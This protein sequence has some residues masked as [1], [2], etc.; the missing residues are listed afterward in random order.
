MRN[1]QLVAASEKRWRTPALVLCFALTW[2]M[3]LVPAIYNRFPLLFPDT[4]AY[5]KV[6]YGGYWTIDRSGFYGLMYAPMRLSDTSLG[7]WLAAAAQCAVVALIL[8]LFARRVAPKATPTALVLLIG[9]SALFTSLPWHAAQLM[10]DAYTAVL[11]LTVWLAASRN[12]DEPG[13]LLLWLLAALLALTHYTH[14]VLLAI[15][16]AAALAC[17]AATRIPASELGKRA[18]ALLI[19]VSAVAGTQVAVNGSLFGRW[20]VS[21]LGPWFMFAR[22]NE[23]G[24]VP[25]WFDGH[26]GKDGPEELCAIR[27]ALP[28]DSQVLLWSSSSPLYPVIHEQRGSPVTW[29]WVDMLEKAAMGSMREQPAAFARS[30]GR[31]ALE[32][33][34]HFRTLDDLCPQE[35]QFRQFIAEHPKLAGPIRSSRQLR[36]ELPKNMIRTVQT[37]IAAAGLLLLPALFFMARR[38]KDPLVA[39][40]IATT[41]I[42]LFA[43]AALAGGLSD[44]HDRYQ[45]RVVWLAPFVVLLVAARWYAWSRARIRKT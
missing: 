7:L 27:G 39:G 5:L 29:H 42:C 9:A 10:P 18:V 19:A 45:S 20:T 23:D 15:G 13:T 36:K 3:L 25:R 43:N 30:M 41:S 12:L 8:L 28:K 24:L 1:E 17:G 37:P 11:I 38:R 26:C 31:G 21:P 33:F 22:L 4:S 2:A 14:F 34:V 44:V 35:C 6:A 40:L 32:Q 16:G